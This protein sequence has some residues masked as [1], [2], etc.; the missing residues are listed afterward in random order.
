MMNDIETLIFD[1]QQS[2]KE[3]VQLFYDKYKRKD[4]LNAWH[5]RVF[6]SVGCFGKVMKRYNFHGIGLCVEL[7]DKVVEFDFGPDD[8]IDGYD[9]WRLF[10]FAD[11]QEKH[12]GLWTYKQIDAEL[13]R[14]EEEQKI[15]KLNEDCSNNYYWK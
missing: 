5:Q 15:I 11:S 3:V 12:K 6:P 8:R 9:A 14:L 4:L 1:F 2:V 7:S 13:K 10:N